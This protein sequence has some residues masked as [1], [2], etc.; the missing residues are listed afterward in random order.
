MPRIYRVVSDEDSEGDL[1]FHLL[2]AQHSSHL[3]TLTGETN[4]RIQYA[5]VEWKDME[6]KDG[7]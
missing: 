7:E 3:A 4:V 6:V 1:W 5:D 2:K